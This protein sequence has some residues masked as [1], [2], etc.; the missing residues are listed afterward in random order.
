M[1]FKTEPKLRFFS[2]PN[3]TWFRTSLIISN[4]NKTYYSVQD[5][6]IQ[7]NQLN[8]ENWFSKKEKWTLCSILKVNKATAV[9]PMKETTR[10]LLVLVN[11]DRLE[12]TKSDEVGADED[13]QL[14]AFLFTFLAVT[15]VT[16]MLHAHP[17]LVHLGKV[18]LDEVNGVFDASNVCVTVTHTICH[19]THSTTATQ[20]YPLYNKCRKM[21]HS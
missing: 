10:H 9:S 12:L 7:Q 15:S 2:K 6:L 14:T 4:F 5:I 17:Q 3:R 18:E 21:L 13:T 19:S 1:F 8:L 20:I 16:L 11:V